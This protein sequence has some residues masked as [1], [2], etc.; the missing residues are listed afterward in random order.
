[1]SRSSGEEIPNFPER[2]LLGSF[3]FS[4]TSGEL[5]DGSGDLVRLRSQSADVLAHLLRHNGEVVSKAAL[6]DAVWAGAAVTDDSLVQCVSEI[7]RCLGDHRHLIVGT[8]SKKGYIARAQPLPADAAAGVRPEDDRPTIAVLAFDDYSAGEDKNYLSDAIAEGV[9]AELTRF[10]EFSIAARNS[11]FVFRDAPTA[12]DEIARRLGV[13]YLVEG[14]QQKAG[15]RLRVTAQ[16]IDAQ[17]GRH[18]WSDVYDQPL[19][20]LFSAQDDVIRRIVATVAQKIVKHHVRDADEGTRSQRS[21]LMH[22]LAGRQHLFRFTPEANEQARL[23]N[24][25]AIEADPTQPYGYVGLA[26]VYINSHRWGEASPGV[27]NPLAEARKSARKALEL[28]PDY[29]DGYGAMAYVHLEEN[30][31][32]RAIASSERALN[33]NPNDTNAMCDLADFLGYAGRVDEA[34]AILRKAMRL[35]PLHA[36]WVRWNMAWLQWL[37]GE[38]DQAL[39][40]MN[41]MFEIPPL[42]NRVLA[43]I[44]VSL[45]RREEGR[46]AVQRLIDFDPG[47]SIA[48]VRKDYAGKFRNSSELDRILTCLREAGLPG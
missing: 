31:L 6:F 21:A 36:D 40:T 11:G 15:D 35:D 33:L 26:F 46:A 3:S 9:I 4:L 37:D 5:R 41:A 47:Y 39:R 16:L 20:D 42:A 12:V 28:A 17:D 18:V 38:Y 23:A 34:Q 27:D 24:L 48:D 32:E 43:L 8:V 30:D 1:M 25:A 7:R 14:S 2:F 44:Y 29:Y 10:S 22:H 19:N 13:R 45:G